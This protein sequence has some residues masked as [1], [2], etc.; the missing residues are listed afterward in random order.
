MGRFDMC[1]TADP[2]DRDAMWARRTSNGFGNRIW[3]AG[4]PWP[5]PR[6]QDVPGLHA[7]MGGA[8]GCHA[9]RGASYPAVRQMT[10][11]WATGLA[12]ARADSCGAGGAGA[13]WLR[14]IQS[15]QWM[16]LVFLSCSGVA[17]ADCAPKQIPSAP[18]GIDAMRAE[19]NSRCRTRAYAAVNVTARRAACCFKLCRALLLHDRNAP[20]T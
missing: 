11:G 12:A 20:F 3:D 13:S 10:G 19:A 6:R 14:T 18:R 5:S 7:E 15:G 8:R 2:V 9:R 17:C 16:R 4:K 1:M